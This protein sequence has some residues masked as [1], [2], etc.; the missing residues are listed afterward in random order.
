MDPVSELQPAQGIARQPKSLY[1]AE[2]LCGG[3]VEILG[4][5]TSSHSSPIYI[6]FKKS[7]QVKYFTLLNAESAAL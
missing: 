5:K 2:G 3:G 6:E 1:E 4:F 7:S